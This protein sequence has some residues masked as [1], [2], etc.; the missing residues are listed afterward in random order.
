M[1]KNKNDDSNFELFLK[2]NFGE[3]NHSSSFIEE[4]R[5]LFNQL[6]KADED[7]EQ[8]LEDYHQKHFCCPKCG[9]KETSTT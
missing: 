7:R 6:K 4:K 8:F 3:N 2:I 5:N 9:A 1:K